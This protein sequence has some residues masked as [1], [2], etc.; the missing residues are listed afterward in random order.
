MGMYNEVSHDCPRCK[1][2]GKHGLGQ[3]QVSQIGPAFG[4]YCLTSLHLLKYK[5]EDKDLTPE[6]LKRVAEASA[7]T[8]FTCE[9]CDHSFKPD[10]AALLAVSMLADRFVSESTV[11]TLTRATAL[12]KDIYPD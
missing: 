1:A 6:Q 8:W 3:G 5:L 7:D 10:P 11:D 2:N 9:E 12:L 4:G